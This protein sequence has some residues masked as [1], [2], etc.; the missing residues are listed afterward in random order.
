M[1]FEKDK[2]IEQLLENEMVVTFN[3]MNGDERVMTCTLKPDLLPPTKESKAEKKEP[4]AKQLENIGVYDL[5]ANAWRS[6]KVANVTNV[7][8][9][10]DA[11]EQLNEIIKRPIRYFQ[12]E[13]GGYGGESV[14]AKVSKEAY[15]FWSRKDLDFNLEDYVF[16]AEDFIEQNDIPE[17]ANFL[18]NKEDDYYQEWFELEN[19]LEHSYGAEYNNTWITVEET[20]TEEFS[21]ETLQDVMSGIDLTALVEEHDIDVDSEQFD[22][23]QFADDDGNN[24]VLYAMSMEKGGF[25]STT[26]ESTTGDFD[27]KQ[28]KFST[29]E[30]PNGDEII[31]GV[32]YK[33]EELDGLGNGD[34]R[35]KG[36][37]ADIWNY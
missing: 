29:M 33:G 17:T 20:D 27:P 26:I 32:E 2:I 13:L 18:Y 34:T 10:D 25:F 1:Q 3:K 11:Y 5:N 28:L 23:D 36:Y 24:Y 4:S 37:T 7:Q 16:D 8:V 35:G 30:M 31:T 6:F 21:S 19:E 15:E 14:Y 12:F 22:L 9:A